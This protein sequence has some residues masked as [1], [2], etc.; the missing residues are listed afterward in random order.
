MGTPNLHAQMKFLNKKLLPDII[1]FCSNNNV[2]VINL[3]GGEPLF[4]R[5]LFKY[6]VNEIHKE[7]PDMKFATTTN[8]TLLDEEIIELFENLDFE[9]SLSLDGNK[10]THDYYRGGFDLIKKRFPRL[11]KLKNITI[12]KQLVNIENLY[13]DV[14]DIWS[15]GFKHVIVN[16]IENKGWYSY[17]D[18]KV[19]EKEYE[20]LILDMID[21]KN[22]Y[23]E[24]AIYIFFEQFKPKKEESCGI[25]E[26][27]LCM[28]VDG[29]LYPCL[30]APELGDDFSIGHI[31][32]GIDSEKEVKIRSYIRNSTLKFLNDNN[33]LL[34]PV[35]IYLENKKFTRP[36]ET[37]S[38]MVNTKEKLIAKHHFELENFVKSIIKNNVQDPPH[39]FRY[40]DIQ[41]RSKGR[42]N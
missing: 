26:D 25:M 33:R 20:K 22:V 41:F 39:Q 34:C 29:K 16:I 10:N 28:Y 42:H 13:R 3:Y 12:N 24:D 6:V 32:S 40:Y 9:I 21:K 14:N 15:F 37:W 19:F 35:S 30:R 38:M 8:G 5:P 27:A 31:R 1:D 4:N 17:A 2:K 11:I 18:V 7:L 23:L 36:H